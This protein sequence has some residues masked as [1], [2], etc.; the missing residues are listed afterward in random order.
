MQARTVAIEQ[1]ARIPGQRQLSLKLS[2]PR[3]GSGQLV[4]LELGIP[5][6]IPVS[7]SAWAFQRD[8]VGD[9]MPVSAA[10]SATGSP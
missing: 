1:R 2:D 9:E 8:S 5:S 6:R 3:V 4:G 7:T 10:I